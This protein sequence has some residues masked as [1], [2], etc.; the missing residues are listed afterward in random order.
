MTEE[1][2]SLW[3]VRFKALEA[4]GLTV[5]AGLGLLQYYLTTNQSRALETS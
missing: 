4:A 3:D 2:H 1:V 5:A